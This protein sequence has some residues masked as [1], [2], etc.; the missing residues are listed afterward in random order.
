[1][2]A[3]IAWIDARIENPPDGVLVLGAVTGRYPADEGEVSSAGQDSWLVI[4]MHLRSVHPVEG[5]DQ[6]IR[7]RYWDCDQV[8]RK[9]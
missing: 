5:S 2:D 1:M 4:A 9:P 3:T 7:G 8:V 6:V